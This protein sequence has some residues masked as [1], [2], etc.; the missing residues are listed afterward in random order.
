MLNAVEML[1]VSRKV[2]QNRKWLILGKGPSSDRIDVDRLDRDFAVVTLNH[3]C[4]LYPNALA[5]HFVDVEA[6]RDCVTYLI[7]K[8]LIMPWH[9][10]QDFRPMRQT[11]DEIARS[12]GLGM[13]VREWNANTLAS[14]NAT[15]AGLLD[16][17]PKLPTIRL[18]LFSAVGAFNLL[19]AAGVKE[20]YTLGVD[21]GTGYGK[22]FDQ[23]DCLA[24]G[25]RSF[26]GQE[27]EILR[28]CRK[29]GV[30]WCRMS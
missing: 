7:P 3:A 15:S 5:Y 22:A 6:A 19:V 28:T 20:I 17:H 30:V 13:F 14:Y 2:Y 26:D 9:P 24:N 16:N 1:R 8:L 21:G 25:R 12:S 18:R 11:L 23:K 29:K 4:R 27:A 10:H